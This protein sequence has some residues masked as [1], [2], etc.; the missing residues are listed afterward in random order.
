MRIHIETVIPAPPEVVF[1]L[2][3]NLEA[4]TESTGDTDEKVISGP[5]SGMME[6]GDEVTFEARHFGIRQ[7]LTSK[8]V[9]YERP[10][11]FTDRMLKG[12]FAHLEH[13]HLFV[14]EGLGTLMIDIMDVEAPLGALGKVFE[15]VILRNY[16]TAFIEK[17]ADS[18]KLMAEELLEE[19]SRKKG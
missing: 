5:E 15:A 8:I 6:L 12:A 10:V 17:R 16:M 2:A 9:A 1:D 3:R 19:Q 13:Q 14:A 11:H 4:H 7:R 18:L